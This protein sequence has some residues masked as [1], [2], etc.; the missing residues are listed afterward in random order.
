MNSLSK[1]EWVWFCWE[2]RV[3]FYVQG[4][5]A[6]CCRYADHP[7]DCCYLPEEQPHVRQQTQQG[8]SLCIQ[9]AVM[10]YALTSLPQRERRKLKQ[11]VCVW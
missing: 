5:T 11:A 4:R 3:C 6:G 2:A 9:E 8:I 10:I 1:S 7:C